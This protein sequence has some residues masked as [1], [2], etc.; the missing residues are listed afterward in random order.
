MIEDLLIFPYS[1]T[2]IEAMDCLNEQWRCIGFVSDD[3]KFIGQE[4]FGITIFSRSAFDKFSHA[5]ILA[6]PGGPTS[7]RKRQSVINGLNIPGKR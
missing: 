7:F 5:K 4:K 2:A 6:V 1:G 3:E